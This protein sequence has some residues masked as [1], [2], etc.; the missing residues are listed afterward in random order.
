[1]VELLEVQ[2]AGGRRMAVA[3]WLRAAPLAQGARFELM[4][5]S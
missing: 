1:V 4:A 3:D 2:R 5:G